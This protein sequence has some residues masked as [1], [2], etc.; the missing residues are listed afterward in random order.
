M[1]TETIPGLIVTGAVSKIAIN[2]VAGIH[3][4]LYTPGW[5]ARIVTCLIVL[6]AVT[7]AVT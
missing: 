3:Q 7:I 5:E 1:K 4:N 2:H 6:A